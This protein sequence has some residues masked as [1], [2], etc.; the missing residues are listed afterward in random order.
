MLHGSRAASSRGGTQGPACV[1]LTMGLRLLV[2]CGP[3]L[4]APGAGL[5]TGF[6]SFG[7]CKCAHTPAVRTLL[8]QG[9]QFNSLN[10]GILL[11]TL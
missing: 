6:W 7:G 8:L 4:I 1:W 9:E 3:L 5:I 2:S 11:F 10:N